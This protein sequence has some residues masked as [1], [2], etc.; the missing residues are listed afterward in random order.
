MNV[1]LFA[2][3]RNSPARALYEKMGFEVVADLGNLSV[4]DD[5][6]IFYVYHHR[7]WTESVKS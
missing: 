4:S 2:T 6:D 5:R 7:E 1:L 3:E